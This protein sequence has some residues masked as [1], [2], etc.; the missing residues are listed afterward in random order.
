MGRKL[1]WWDPRN[2]PAVLWYKDLG[3]R[4]ARHQ[5]QGH[6]AGLGSESRPQS[7]LPHGMR[8]LIQSQRVHCQRGSLPVSLTDREKRLTDIPSQAWIRAE[9]GF[10]LDL[11]ESSFQDT[12]LQLDG[13]QRLGNSPGGGGCVLRAIQ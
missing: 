3:T 8:Y 7:V 12:M 6:T 1:G 2:H 4:E 13:E 10:R 9:E 5:S 11:L